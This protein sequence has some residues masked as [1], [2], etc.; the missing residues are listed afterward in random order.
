M[1]LMLASV[2]DVAEAQAAAA[3]GAD[4]VDL[5]D[6]ARGALPPDGVRA[7]VRATAG[8]RPASA[9]I[10]HSGP[11]PDA[12][13]AAAAAMATTGV[14]YVRVGLPPDPRRADC[15]ARLAPLAREAKLI[16]VLF[17]DRETDAG[18]PSAVLARLRAVGF[19]GAML[20]IAA[21]DS[22]RLLDRMEI[23]ALAEFLNACLGNG[24][25]SGFAGALEPP[26]IPRL[27]PFAPDLLGFCSALRA[28]GD[29][30]APLDPAAFRLV[31]DLIPPHETAPEPGIDYRLLAARGSSHFAKDQTHRIFV[32]DFVLP[33]RIGAYAH[34]RD[35]LQRV[36]FNVDV[37]LLRPAHPAADMRDV[38]SYDLI[39]DGIR[40]IA[41]QDD[42]ALIETLAERI[43]ALVVAHARIVAVTA[44]V[45]KLD[46]G[47]GTVGVEIRRERPA[48]AADVRRLYSVAGSDD[49]AE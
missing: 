38:F 32:R 28:G 1:T 30:A 46:V 27:L 26:D 4:I 40:M 49:P 39:T 19:A 22:G 41:A 33:V 31:R 5:A 25:L 13:A 16:G 3:L 20:D 17:A 24:L 48:E 12:L 6:A 9:A 14:D 11:D 35:K 37:E 10:Y 15:I 43:A 36:R 18:A 42:I 29:R 34:E 23:A 8:R 7:A 2:R 21:A 47:S 45:E 44:R